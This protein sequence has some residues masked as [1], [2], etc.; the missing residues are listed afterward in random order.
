M[1]E[2][3]IDWFNFP[4]SKNR[5]N[6]LYQH[7]NEEHTEIYIKGHESIYPNMVFLVT[8]FKSQLKRLKFDYE[9]TG[10]FCKINEFRR[11]KC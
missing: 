7:K 2:Q 6:I 8:I 5:K 1:K 10:E 3:S 9:Q 4:I 11:K